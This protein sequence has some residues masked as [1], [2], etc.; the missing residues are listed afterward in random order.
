M[1]LPKSEASQVPGDPSRVMPT[2]TAR[3]AAPGPESGATTFTGNVGPG[4]VAIS[5]KAPL[6]PGQSVVVM[7][8][9][10]ERL[11]PGGTANQV[12]DRATPRIRATRAARPA[13]GAEQGGSRGAAAQPGRSSQ[14]ASGGGRRSRVHRSGDRSAHG[15]DAG[16]TARVAVAAR[17][18]ARR[19]AGPVT[20]RGTP[21]PRERLCRGRPDVALPDREATIGANGQ[22]TLHETRPGKVQAARRPARQPS[23]S[24][25]RLDERPGPAGDQSIE[26][27][28]AARSHGDHR[29]RRRRRRGFQRPTAVAPVFGNPAPLEE[30]S[31]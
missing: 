29:E 11:G 7:D 14:C 27:P 2:P 16:T 9:A 22:V 8:K 28:A 4:G 13:P 20:G 3:K 10:V 21:R 30:P 1:S 25:A 19:R 23:G 26:L 18:T 17:S 5:Q 15:A 12:A 24:P 31:D 6:S